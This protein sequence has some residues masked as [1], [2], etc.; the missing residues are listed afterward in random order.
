MHAKRRQADKA[1]THLHGKLHVIMAR[2]QQ[3]QQVNNFRLEAARVCVVEQT[4]FNEF[5]TKSPERVWWNLLLETLK[6]EQSQ[7]SSRKVWEFFFF[8]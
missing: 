1:C 5:Q 7:T 3:R 6:I 2:M 8:W 4:A